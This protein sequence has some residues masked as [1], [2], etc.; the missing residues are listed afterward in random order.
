[1]HYRVLHNQ[2]F[3]SSLSSLPLPSSSSS[4]YLSR[5]CHLPLVATYDQQGFVN[6]EAVLALVSRRLGDFLGDRAITLSMDEAAAVPLSFYGIS[7]GAILGAGYTEFSSLVRRTGGRPARRERGEGNPPSI[8][9]FFVSYRF[10]LF[11]ARLGSFRVMSYYYFV[12][13]LLTSREVLVG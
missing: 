7:Q 1:M 3:L 12:P 5:P 2:S 9:S 8:Y 11:L 13:A 4:C 10:M 6:Q